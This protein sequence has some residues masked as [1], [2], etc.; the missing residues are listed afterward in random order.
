ME[1]CCEND[2]VLMIQREGMTISWL[3]QHLSIISTIS[4]VYSTSSPGENKGE[5]Q[6][7]GERGLEIE[8]D[9]ERVSEQEVWRG[10]ARM[11]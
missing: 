5:T 6:G 7:E 4:T 3:I 1:G 10:A 2:I 11:I 8:S 9:L